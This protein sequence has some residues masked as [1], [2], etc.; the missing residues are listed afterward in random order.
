MCGNEEKTQNGEHNT[1]KSTTTLPNSSQRTSA[2]K[3][4]H[5]LREGKLANPQMHKQR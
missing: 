5:Y 3:T 1:E 2:L 4:M